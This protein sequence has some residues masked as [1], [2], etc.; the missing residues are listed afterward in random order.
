MNKHVGSTLESLFEELGE[1]RELRQLVRAVLL[2]DDE[3]L[4]KWALDGGTPLERELAKKGILVLHRGSKQ[5]SELGA[6]QHNVVLDVAYKGKRAAA[7]ISN[8]YSQVSSLLEFVAHA[9]KMPAKYHKHFPRVY[10]T[11]EVEVESE[12][13]L[14]HLYGAVVEM[15]DPMPPGLEHDLDDQ[16]LVRDKLQRS[17][18][19]ALVKDNWVIDGIVD[20]ATKVLVFQREILDMYEDAIRPH[21]QSWAGKP[22]SDFDEWLTKVTDEHAERSANKRAYNVFN[23]GLLRALKSAVIPH[24]PT[25]SRGGG[26]LPD[27]HASKQVRDFYQ[28]LQEMEGTGM[29]WG[30]LHTGNF[31]MRR[32]TGDLVIVDPGYF[33]SSSDSSRSGSG[34]DPPSGS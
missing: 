11:F 7:R 17:R 29:K 27:N 2:E 6:G 25:T 18:V 23:Q 21:L 19:A 31:M 4:A 3:K 5:E 28:F 22:L 20:D 8:D 12:Y 14:E 10:T 9:K 13:N 34:Y 26:R 30:D 32:G 16:S 15:L 1:L 33:D 24:E